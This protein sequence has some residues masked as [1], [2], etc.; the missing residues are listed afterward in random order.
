MPIFIPPERARR[1]AALATE[2]ERMRNAVA[3]LT[4]D[5]GQLDAKLAYLSRDRRRGITRDALGILRRTGQPMLLGD[6]VAALMVERGIDAADRALAG[7]L[8]EQIRVA[9]TRQWQAGIVRWERGL[10]WA[11]KWAVATYVLDIATGHR[12]HQKRQE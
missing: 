5:L 12:A 6:I 7:Q 3:G 11:K 2:V 9:L 4:A 8:K 10:G 1:I